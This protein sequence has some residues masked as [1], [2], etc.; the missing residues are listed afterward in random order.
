MPP[1][2]PQR[3]FTVGNWRSRGQ[4]LKA[5]LTPGLDL[6][7]P[8]CCALC[9]GELETSRQG[10][11]CDD[12][13]GDLVDP[14]PAC[15][16]CAT[17]GAR[18]DGGACLRCKDERYSF[19]AVARLGS[20]GG[21]LR[22]AL[23]RIKQS[24]ERGLAVA[25]GDLLAAEREVEWRAMELDGVVPV[26]MHWSRRLWR[27][28]NSPETI[29]ERVA[30][31]LGLPLAPHLLARRRRT[32]P[33]ASLPPSRRVTNVRGA[34]RAAKHS[35]LAGARLLLVD[36]IMTTGATV[37]EAAKMLRRS[38]AASVCIAVLARAEGLS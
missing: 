19:D 12:C 33:Q 29:A 36:D 22:S 7:F 3:R 21:S 25:L 6:V 27:G 5:W 10:L 38:G 20:Y 37:N 34:F 17:S 16:R 11:I 13:R 24:S 14:H 31:R 9:R 32:A 28:A 8:P 4:Y 18:I 26:P 1:A 23:L 2:A 35:D 15:P 30:R